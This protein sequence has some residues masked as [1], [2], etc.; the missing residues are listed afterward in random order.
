MSQSSWGGGVNPNWYIVP[1][2]LVFFS[3]T[4]PYTDGGTNIF[5]QGKGTEHF[6][7]MYKGGEVEILFYISGKGTNIFTQGGL[8][9][10]FLF[11]NIFLGS[12][13]LQSEFNYNNSAILM[14]FDIIEIN[15]V[16]I[17]IPTLLE[18]PAPN[19]TV[20]RK[21]WPPMPM[22][23]RRILRLEQIFERQIF[24]EVLLV[25]LAGPT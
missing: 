5:I 8:V 2:F 24:S 14:G 1:N 22:R 6:Q 19:A 15:L 17:I 9:Q 4:S 11:D 13:L 25:Q 3:D 10:T 20:I 7:T 12:L 23:E 18:S 16:L 21:I